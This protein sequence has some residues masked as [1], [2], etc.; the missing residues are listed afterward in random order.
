MTTM[1]SQI[2]SLTFVYLIVYSGADQRKHQ[3]SASLAF[4][5]GIHRSRWIPRQRSSNTENVSIWWRHHVKN[6]WN[7]I[8]KNILET[9]NHIGYFNQFSSDWYKRTTAATGVVD[10]RSATRYGDISSAIL[11]KKSD[12]QKVIQNK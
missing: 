9:N 2:T 6:L 7:F 1:T 8:K 3:S 5:R 11:K 12:R 10:N 4:V